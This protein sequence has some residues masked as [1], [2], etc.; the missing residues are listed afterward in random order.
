MRTSRFAVPA[1]LVV[2]TTLVAGSTAQARRDLQPPRFAGLE[3]AVTCIA[4]PIGGDRTTSY[5]LRW[6]PARD[7]ITPRYAIVYDIY[8]A[9]TSGGQDF[10]TPTYTTRRGSTYFN[11]PPLPTSETFF[12]VVRARD[13]AGNRD[14]NTVERQGVN[15]CV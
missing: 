7:N 9:T 11:T 2:L 12:F 1:L 15:L 6:R 14:S 8:Q 3:S 5:H 13:L 10:S 4:G